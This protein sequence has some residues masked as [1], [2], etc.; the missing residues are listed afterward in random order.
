MTL[1]VLIV[2]AC[3]CR[4]EDTEGG[5]ELSAFFILVPCLG[6]LHYMFFLSQLGSQLSFQAIFV[7]PFS[8][9]VLLPGKDMVRRKVM[10][11]LSVKSN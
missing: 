8:F 10:G 1:T 5:G 4:F 7:E 11:I 9:Q 3:I 2:L 6:M